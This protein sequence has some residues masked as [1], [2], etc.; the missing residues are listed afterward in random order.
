MPWR[1]VGRRGVTCGC[2]VGGAGRQRFERNKKRRERDEQ[3]DEAPVDR[4][5][6]MMY[7]NELRHLVNAAIAGGRTKVIRYP[8]APSHA[9]AHL[10]RLD[11]MVGRVQC[12]PLR[13]YPL[14][15]MQPLCALQVKPRGGGRCFEEEQTCK[16]WLN[17]NTKYPGGAG[18]GIYCSKGCSQLPCLASVP[19]HGLGWAVDSAKQA[20]A[21]CAEADMDDGM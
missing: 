12:S 3:E 9:Y 14:P 17:G 21:N 20:A 4:A 8:R 16:A 2:V 7:V 15:P 18:I 19:K 11:G 5:V 13:M 10:L 6:R 1:A